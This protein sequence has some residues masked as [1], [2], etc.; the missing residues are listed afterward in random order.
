MSQL[1]FQSDAIADGAVKTFDHG[2]RKILIVRDGEDY[3]AFDGKCPHAG[4]DLGKGA[5]CAGRLVCPWHH[6]TFDMHSGALLEPLPTVGLKRYAVHRDGDTYTVDPDAPMSF[7]EP[8]PVRA[9]EHVV[10]VGAGGGGFMAAHTLRQRG[11]AGT[12]TLVDPEHALPYERPML[13]K[14]FLSGKVDADA[15]GIGGEGWEK[16][17]RI[18]RRYAR[19]TAIEPDQKRLLL[20]HGEPLSWDHLIVATGSEPGDGGLEGADL[21]GVYRLRN[22]ADAE[23]LRAAAQGKGVVIVGSSFIGMEAAASLV[24]KGGAASVTVVAKAAEVMQPTLGRD[25]AR[26]LRRL[27][28]SNGVTFHLDATIKRLAGNGQVSGVELADGSTLEADVVLLGVGVHPRAQLLED[29]ADDDGAIPVDSQM[30]VRDTVYAVGDIA[31]APTVLGPFRIEHWRVAMQ[32]GM[33]A[34]LSILDAPGARMDRRVPFFWSGQFGKSLRYVGHGAADA[35][36]HVWGDPA[37]LDFIEFSFD[38]ERTVAAVGMQRDTA[39]AAFE[40]L[41]KLGR[42]PGAAEIR[43]G[44]FDLAQRLKGLS[45][46]NS[47][48]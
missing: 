3:R 26:E 48:A 4:A 27:H 44:E 33:V 35:P 46:G 10:I 25:T 47:D 9:D 24:G 40:L 5:L 22:L 20:D 1:S 30:R 45:A 34:A 21:V 18:G 15:I 36:H 32:Q 12:I 31:L 28:E 14:Q 29:F 17:Q 39:M 19:A 38:G 16:K 37:K 8:S 2:D 7:P 23:A 6:G 11:F 42:V 43:A 13:S 41:L